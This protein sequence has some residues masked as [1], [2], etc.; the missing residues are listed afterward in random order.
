MCN[1]SEEMN[2]RWL[3]ILAIPQD[4]E[5]SIAGG[6]GNEGACTF[7]S[8]IERNYIFH[9]SVFIEAASNI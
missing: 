2:I 3:N 4:A 8:F 7:F 6:L 9:S 5:H 1:C